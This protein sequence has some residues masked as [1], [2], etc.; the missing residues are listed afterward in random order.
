MASFTCPSCGAAIKFHSSVTVFTVCAYCHST[1]LRTDLKLEHI[2][3]MAILKQD[4]TPIQ[5]GT[6]G[7]F[8]RESF[9]VIGRVR[10]SWKA[11]FWNEWYLY[12]DGVTYGWLAEAQG[13]YGVLF[14]KLDIVVPDQSELEIGQEIL[15]QREN[16][17]IDDIKENWVSY[18]EGELPFET[19]FKKHTVTVDLTSSNSAFGSIEYEALSRSVYLGRYVDFEDLHFKN[20]RTFDGW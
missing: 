13:F 4:P 9:T 7:R 15:I 14:P 18:A 16:L 20:L 2:G 5:L 3:Q 6:E 1:L 12:F 11:G 19:N 8:G 10:K 17:V